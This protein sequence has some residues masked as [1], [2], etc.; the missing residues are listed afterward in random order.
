MALINYYPLQL[1]LSAFLKWKIKGHCRRNN[2]PA[3]KPEAFS[4]F[5][6]KLRM[7]SRQYSTDKDVRRYRA[8]LIRI[9]RSTYHAVHQPYIRVDLSS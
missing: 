7:R 9:Y 3:N 6:A 1:K 2:L 5:G 4:A 8:P